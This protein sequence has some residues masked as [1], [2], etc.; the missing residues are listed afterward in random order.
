MTKSTMKAKSSKKHPKKKSSNTVHPYIECVQKE[1]NSL[2][3]ELTL[4]ESKPE[5]TTDEETQLAITRACLERYQN[6]LVKLTEQTMTSKVQQLNSITENEIK[7]KEETRMFLFLQVLYLMR[8]GQLGLYDFIEQAP[9]LQ[10]VSD[11]C[12]Q[13]IGAAV[14][15]AKDPSTQVKEQKRHQIRGL[16]RKL[17]Y[18]SNDLIEESNTTTFKQIKNFL[19]RI[20]DNTVE[21]TEH[22]NNNN[23][24]YSVIQFE[25]MVPK[26]DLADNT[27]TPEATNSEEL[28]LEPVI[29]STSN[30]TI[31]SDKLDTT[32]TTADACKNEANTTIKDTHSLESETNA[33]KDTTYCDNEPNAV[34]DDNKT[35]AT[36]DTTSWDIET[37]DSSQ[38]VTFDSWEKESEPKGSTQQ[39]ADNNGWDSIDNQV[40]IDN[41]DSTTDRAWDSENVIEESTSPAAVESRDTRVSSDNDNWRNRD[42]SPGREKGRGRGGRGRGRGDRGGRARGRG[43]G[44]GGV[45]GVGRGRGRGHEVDEDYNRNYSPQPQTQK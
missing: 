19:Q 23:Q 22:V 41:W 42:D 3:E 36:K 43:R 38:Q 4:L 9:S 26:Q 8:L 37:L 12:D 35:D 1:I 44:R 28:A 15:Y 24:V 5:L 31:D 45:R 7:Q 18:G 25:G 16:L 30:P 10:S 40:K 27:R 21:C 33:P 32:S 29:E 39:E 20:W 34:N 2:Q 11:L 14:Y 6:T 17:E 13:I